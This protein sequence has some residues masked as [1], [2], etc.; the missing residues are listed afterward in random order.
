MGNRATFS[1]ESRDATTTF[2]CRPFKCCCFFFHRRSQ[3]NNRQ[4]NC[5][6]KRKKK[7]KGKQMQQLK[8]QWRR[9]PTC[10]SESPMRNKSCRQVLQGIF[11][12]PRVPRLKENLSLMLVNLHFE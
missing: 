8:N 9:Q 7:K 10:R 3:L 5:S 11:H 1:T 2:S 6:F 12:S 4:R